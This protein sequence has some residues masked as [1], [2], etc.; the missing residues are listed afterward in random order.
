MKDI[1]GNDVQAKKLKKNVSVEE[2]NVISELYIY[3]ETE[4]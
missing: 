1:H 4:L 3:V 2:L